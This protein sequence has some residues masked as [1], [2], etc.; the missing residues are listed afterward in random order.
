MI[1]ATQSCHGCHNP[2]F[3][4]RPARVRVEFD[5]GIRECVLC[6]RCT[7]EVGRSK[8]SQ[9]LWI[10]TGLGRM[11]KPIVKRENDVNNLSRVR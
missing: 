3:S 4:G 5:D 2:Y 10:T 11:R 1:T 7:R 8:Y 9:A 6:A